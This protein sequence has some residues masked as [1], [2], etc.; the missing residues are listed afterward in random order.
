MVSLVGLKDY[1][2]TYSAIRLTYLNGLWVASKTKIYLCQH[3]NGE[4][5]PSSQLR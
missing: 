4:S 3:I 1:T 2:Y 5:I